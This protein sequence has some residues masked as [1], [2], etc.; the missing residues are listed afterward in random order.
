M[1]GGWCV[2]ETSGSNK[3]RM[4]RSIGGT[5]LPSIAGAMAPPVTN[6]T[7]HAVVYTANSTTV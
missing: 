6:K 2:H 1:C 4:R 3:H 7:T 5:M